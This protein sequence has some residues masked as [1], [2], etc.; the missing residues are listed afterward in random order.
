MGDK[1]ELKKQKQERTPSVE[2]TNPLDDTENTTL[3]TTLNRI[4][5]VLRPHIWRA[6][7]LQTESSSLGSSSG[8]KRSPEE[9]FPTGITA[10][11]REIGG[12][13]KGA[14]H[15][16]IL[17]HPSNLGSS[18]IHPDVLAQ[19][20]STLCACAALKHAYREAGY[21][22]VFYKCIAWIGKSCWPS[23]FFLQEALFVPE[24]KTQ[25]CKNVL[26]LNPPDERSHFWAIDTALRS[27]ATI[28]VVST[29][30]RLRFSMSR[31]LSLAAK[32]GESIGILH[33]PP[34]YKGLSSASYS[35]WQL[36]H[37]PTREAQPEF[38][39]TLLKIKHSIALP[40]STDLE[41]VNT[42]LRKPPTTENISLPLR[43]RK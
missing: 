15:E 10:L 34:Q 16:C 19:S 21:P 22:K 27:S 11:D 41:F 29:L 35:R 25:L 9:F 43:V 24:T 20:F 26:F 6:E 23:P 5:D 7:R 31:R 38:D 18:G 32:K 3:N 2:I 37:R 12:L 36:S 17:E 4:E 42:S 8:S 39:L 30:K 14:L 40:W 28:A 33:L 13:R 1:S